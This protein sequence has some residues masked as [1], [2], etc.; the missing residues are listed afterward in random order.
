MVGQQQN[1]FGLQPTEASKWITH[2]KVS[3]DDLAKAFACL[4]N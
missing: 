2:R 4:V 1:I 3:L